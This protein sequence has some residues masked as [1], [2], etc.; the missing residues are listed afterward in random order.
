MES[1]VRAH[2]SLGEAVRNR[3]GRRRESRNRGY[4]HD[5]GR[6][7]LAPDG[8]SAMSPKENTEEKMEG[9][10]GAGDGEVDEMLGSL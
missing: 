10:M 4:A 3:G 2:E 8:I 1:G 9:D 6:R 5:E 7:R